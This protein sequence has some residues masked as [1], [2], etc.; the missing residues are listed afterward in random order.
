PYHQLDVRVDKKYFFEKW[1]LM[2]YV[3]IQ[4]L[5]N[6]KAELQD[7]IVREKDGDGNIITVDNNTKY[8]LR[9]I[10]NTS[11]TVLPTLGIMVE[12]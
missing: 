2:V 8:L 9:G 7:N 4:N 1:S 10:E 11:G 6:F 5:Y 3:D 12:F